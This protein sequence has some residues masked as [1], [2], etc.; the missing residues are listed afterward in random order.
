MLKRFLRKALFYSG[1]V[2]V[3]LY[4][5]THLLLASSPVQNKVLI[6][7][8][9]AL[10]DL[11]IDIEM[12][13][14][15]F[16]TF[17]PKLYLNRVTLNTNAKAEVTLAEPLNIDK[18]RIEFSPLALIYREILIDEVAL[19]HPKI[20]LPQADVLYQKITRLASDKKAS[21]LN[22]PGSLNVKIK[23]F[24]VVDALVHVISKNP[25]FELHSRSLSAFLEQNN[26]G[27]Q[28]VQL[29]SNHFELMYEKLH[30]ELNRIDV[31]VDISKNSVRANRLILE[32][33]DLAVNIK[34]A[35]SLPFL[36]GN[37]IDSSHVNYSIKLPI[38]LLSKISQL[39]LPV[40][41]GIVSSTGSLDANK[42]I[43]SGKGDIQYAG[44]TVDGFSLDKGSLDFSLSEKKLNVT[45]IN[46]SM[47]S[48]SLVS[49]NVSVELSPQFPIEGQIELKSLKLNSLVEAL[50]VKNPPLRM[51]IDGKVS[52]TG[53]LAQPLSIDAELSTQLKGFKVYNRMNEPLTRDNTILDIKQAALG[54]HFNI[55]DSRVEFSSE[56]KALNGVLNS[57]GTFPYKGK[58]KINSTGKDLSLT[59]LS[60]IASVD[61]AGKVESLTSSVTIEGED[62]SVEGNFD[63]KQGEINEMVL[64]D[65][66]GS[67]NYDDMLLSFENLYLKGIQPIS[68]QGF[69]D[70]RPKD[71]HYKFNVNI[72]RVSVEQAFKTFQKSKLPFPNPVGGE[73]TNGRIQIEGGHDDK[74]IE[75]KISGNARNFNWYQESWLSSFYS[76]NYRENDVDFRRGIFVKKSGALEVT[77]KFENKKSWMKFLSHALRLEEFTYF[78]SAPLTGEV[79]GEI[80]VEGDLTK[81]R[82]N[83]ELKLSRTAFRGVAIPDS[84]IKIN[85]KEG[86]TEFAA[87][88]AGDKLRARWTK[89]PQSD[90]TENSSLLLFFRKMDL[91]P[92]LTLWLGKDIPP[93]ETITASG[94]FSLNGNFENTST[95]NGSGIFNELVL[96]L[97]TAPL[98]NEKPIEVSINKGN[99]QVSSFKLWGEDSQLSG[100]FSLEQ[101]KKIAANLDGK[102]DLQFIQPFIPGLAYG[103][104]K[105]ACNFRMSGHPDKYSVLGNVN[106]DD[107]VFRLTGLESEF[108]SAKAQLTISQDKINVDKFDAV[109]GAGKVAVYGEV[110]IDRFTRFKPNLQVS[111]SEVSLKI[112]PYL[113]LQASGDLHI[114]GNEAPYLMGGN[115]QILESKLTQLSA[116]EGSELLPETPALKFDITADAPGKLFVI[117]NVLDSE[118]K[119]S[120]RV[121]GD[122][123]KI[124]MVGSLE[125][126]KG[127]MLFK[128][129]KFG[130][131]NGSVKF[132]D[133]SRIYPRFNF[134][135]RAYV[136]EQVTNPR[137]YEVNLRVFGVPEDYKIR[138]T[139]TPFLSEQDLIALL[140]LGV[141]DREKGG[142]SVVDLGTSLVGETPF[143]SKLKN[144]L[145][146]GVKVQGGQNATITPGTTTGFD[147]LTTDS[148]ANGPA[149]QV[150]KDL[151]KRTK[152]SAS[153]PIGTG[154][155]SPDFKIEHI[156][157]DNFSVNATSSDKNK[158][159]QSTTN[160][161]RSYGIDFRY[162]F[163]FE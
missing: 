87:T 48:G 65:V 7:L 90:G 109:L 135:G 159:A 81:P 147:P 75:V 116:G 21:S 133:S 26:R 129:Q 63:L 125:T 139:S 49:D 142:G 60:H 128:E 22:R 57:T 163:T 3:I 66:T 40:L 14:F 158:G 13:S 2:F 120:L 161:V 16:A 157:D 114:K 85:T 35:S 27:Q 68:G 103:I 98:R 24:G 59:E 78:G 150:Q 105:V 9:L 141:T 83:G 64:G 151:G 80:V 52:L 102:M 33:K 10:K 17:S 70:F 67:A 41:G 113:S 93:L 121:L 137:E 160:S 43:Y 51:E 145:G 84:S 152:L 140:V 92:F 72:P 132:E 97:R 15:E 8:K 115:I 55:S 23:K 107:A 18:I 131:L 46:A 71:N 11:G 117:T 149:V 124:A 30:L 123:N 110:G 53:H 77:G 111:V 73:V 148:A 54:A 39:H 118:F 134:S 69:V 106:I 12:E 153:S 143:Q 91:S 50:K 138:L 162:N 154:K 56:I 19:F 6:E 76:I 45:R 58:A 61:F 74:G 94:D 42:G 4:A 20:L 89:T 88:M 99:V 79:N 36:K 96:G 127:D 62:V 144:E 130:I 34:G 136:K 5:V 82:G 25:G 122:T 108:R 47:G 112:R 104:G 31:D 32:G 126:V 155:T 86:R 1:L 100:S 38:Q 37:N 119:G 29:D 95:L 146:L 28:T 101:G 44:V 156:L